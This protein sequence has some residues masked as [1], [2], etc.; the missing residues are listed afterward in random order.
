MAD[1]R[2]GEDGPAGPGGPPPGELAR[3]GADAA[4]LA[5]AIAELE[6]EMTAAARRLEFER[7]ASLR[8]RVE[9][10]V[11][12]ALAAGADAAELAGAVEQ[13][14]GPRAGA[15]LAGQG[16]SRGGRGGGRAR[17]R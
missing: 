9:E 10:L 3:L 5:R 12:E 13:A 14:L 8:D 15:V 11:A 4:G 7:A 17:R 6:R 1:A 16:R 2:A